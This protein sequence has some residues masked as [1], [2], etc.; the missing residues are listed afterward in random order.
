M[1]ILESI[2][3]GVVQGITEWLPIS[4]SGHLVIFQQFL[5]LEVPLFFDILLHFATLIVILI[6]FHKDIIKILKEFPSTKKP[7]GKLGWYIIIGSVPI[8]LTGFFLRDQIAGLFTSIKAVAIALLFTSLLLF[9]SERFPGK[10]KLKWYDSIVIGISQALALIPGI[11]RSGSTI[12]TGLLLGLEKRQVATFSFLLVIPAILGATILEFS[13]SSIE[14]N[15]IYGF[16]TAI[17]VGYASLKL[18]LRLI[19]KNKF[20][21]FGWYCLV[22]GILLLII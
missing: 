18:L 3:L 4:S 9:L 10:R 11:S 12:S 19:V 20:H 2:L 6:V 15:Y 21:Y 16:L 22:L 17:I 8:A 13:I 1:N 14:F 5:N 7:N